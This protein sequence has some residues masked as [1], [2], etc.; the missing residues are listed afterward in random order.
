MTA[1]KLDEH[2][3]IETGF[4]VPD[5]Y[6][7]ALS[8]KVN[9]AISEQQPQVIPITRRKTWM[10]AAAA[11]L[12]IGLGVTTFNALSLQPNAT[13]SA[14]IE[15]YLA[16]QSATEDLLVDALEKEDI[17]KLS[18]GYDLDDHAIEEVLSNNAN[19][20]QYIID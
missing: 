13:D 15:N 19:L 12:V 18:A 17:E 1:F 7:D 2:P 9:L 14:A 3:K 16:T 10:Y 4:K 8:K 5:G 20:E 6:F 11:V